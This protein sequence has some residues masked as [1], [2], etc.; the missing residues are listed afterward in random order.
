[1]K[2]QVQFILSIIS[3]S[4]F[5]SLPAIAQTN[6]GDVFNSVPTSNGDQ[7]TEPL[8]PVEETNNREKPS[9]LTPTTEAPR[10]DNGVSGGRVDRVEDSGANDTIISPPAKPTAPTQ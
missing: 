3:I 1:M 9:L 2:R 10:R 5:A 4:A 6:I 8:N 7:L